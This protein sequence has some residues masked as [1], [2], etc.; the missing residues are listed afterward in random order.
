MATEQQY[1]RNYA[2]YKL[3]SGLEFGAGS[4][5]GGMVDAFKIEVLSALC[6]SHYL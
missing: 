2:L 3:I 6:M 5:L 1:G 4:L